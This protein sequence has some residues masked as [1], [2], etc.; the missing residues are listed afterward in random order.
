[1]SKLN[2]NWA[3]GNSLNRGAPIIGYRG[4]NGYYGGSVRRESDVVRKA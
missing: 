3:D 4:E 1:M 2:N